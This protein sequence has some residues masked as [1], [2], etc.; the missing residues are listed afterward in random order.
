[1]KPQALRNFCR[2]LVQFTCAFALGTAPLLAADSFPDVSQLPAH[3][4]TPDPLTMLSG[5]KVTTPAQWFDQRRPELKALFQHYMYGTLPPAP[6]HIHFEVER[7]DHAMFGGKATKKEVSIHF[8]N[9]AGAP[10]IHLLVVVPNSNKSNPAP[11]Q[12]DETRRGSAATKLASREPLRVGRGSPVFVGMNFCGNHTLVTNRDV[13][14]PEGWVSKNCPGCVD[15]HAT[16]AGRGTQLDIWNIEQSIDRG[17]AVATFYCGDIEPDLTNATTGLRAFLARQAAAGKIS[18]SDCGIIAAWAWGLSRCVD[19]LV[20]DQDIDPKRIA[21]VGHSRF[22][23]AA[24][25]AAAM[26]ERFALAVP[27]QAGCGGTA[28]SRGTTGE[29]VKAINESFPHWFNAEF[30]T[31]NEQTGRLPFD[32]NCLIALVAPRAVLLGAAAGDTWANPAGAFEMLQSADPVYRLLGARG[33]DEKQM[34]ASNQLVG[35]QL[36][37]FIR[38]GKHSMTKLDWQKFLDFADRVMP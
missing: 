17:Y 19:Y 26:D 10:V 5:A 13:A 8:S 27:L 22:G 16:D 25:L 24:M 28:P 38:P 35:D 11:T 20:T 12:P 37:Y 29:S 4:E 21:V 1:M 9:A 33:L 7:A 6:E 3:P 2:R 15:N 36:G 18:P 32:Q 23:K 31:F 34:P 30:K 14:L